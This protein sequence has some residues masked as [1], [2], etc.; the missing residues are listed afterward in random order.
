MEGARAEV[1]AQ[2]PARNQKYRRLLVGRVLG[3][4]WLMRTL[5]G[6]AALAQ[7]LRLDRVGLG[8]WRR[9]RPLRRLRLMPPTLVG[10]SWRSVGDHHDSVAL[11]AGCVMDPWFEEVHAATVNVLRRAGIDVQVPP[12]QTCCGALAAHDGAADD[13][14]RMAARNIAAFDEAGTIVV[15][16]AGCGAHLKDYR[17]YGAPG[18]EMAGR[19]RDV[20][21]IVAAMIDVG[22]LPV[23]DQPLGPVAVQDPCHLKY[24]QG[25]IEAPRSILRAAGYDPQEVDASGT[26]CG[27]GG[28]YSLLQPDTAD[29]LGRRK[30]SEVLATG[31]PTVATANPGCE[32]QLRQHLTA[33]GSRVR[34]V[35]PIELYWEALQRVRP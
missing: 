28:I 25:I 29:A 27:A 23:L 1:A 31:A 6:L 30:A 8:P 10:M 9:L 26:C 11:L 22:Q 20:T 15:N 18:A 13:A 33:I 32:L 3:N 17:V 2:V 14:V 16:A 24:A 4:R 19:V 21:E 12:D 34:V 5:T 7:R 35:H